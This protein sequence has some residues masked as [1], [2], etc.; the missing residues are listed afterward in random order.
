LKFYIFKLFQSFWSRD[1]FSWWNSSKIPKEKLAS[2]VFVVH[3]VRISSR[4]YW[5]MFICVY[6]PNLCYFW[7]DI[8]GP[9]T[10]TCLHLCF[11]FFWRILCRLLI[12]SCVF[13]M[14]KRKDDDLSEYEKK[15][16]E[17][18]NRNLDFLEQLGMLSRCI[19][20]CCQHC[21]ENSVCIVAFKR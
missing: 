8:F 18:I 19:I 6:I 9:S 21:N 13:R 11:P 7:S 10:Q 1:T 3:F 4:D 17:N 16:I 20:L 12:F 15:R 14:P 5:G 2:C